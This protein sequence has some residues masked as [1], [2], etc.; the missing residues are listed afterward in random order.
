MIDTEFIKDW[1]DFSGQRCY[2]L[3]GVARRKHNPEI[4]NRREE[5]HR[6]ILTDESNVEE[7]ANILERRISGSDLVHTVYLQVNARDPVASLLD[8]RD[9]FNRRLRDQIRHPNRGFEDEFAININS[10]YKSELMRHSIEDDPYFLWDLDG[11]TES[12]L[13]R[14]MNDIINE[15]E[16]AAH[17]KTENGWHVITEPFN[18]IEWDAPIDVDGFDTDGSVFINRIDG[19]EYGN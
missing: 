4:T 8:T 18:Y 1:C 17:R 7:R 6:E 13:T 10:Q 11:V 2:I 19:S 12:E 15:T 5:R 16:V 9:Y 3:W 14:F